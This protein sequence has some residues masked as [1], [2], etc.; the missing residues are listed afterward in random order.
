MPAQKTVKITEV[1]TSIIKSNNIYNSTL[2]TIKEKVSLIS[3]RPSTLYLIIKYVMEEV[4]KTPIKGPEQKE[5]ALKLIK[6]LIIDLTEN[7][8]EKVLLDLLNDG[9]IGNL[10]DLIVDVSKGKINI[11]KISSVSLGCFKRCYPYLCKS[12][13]KK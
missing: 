6:A 8:D 5:I 13:S 10:I 1:N 4:E 3:I 9:T 7:E 12:K 11:N 2:E